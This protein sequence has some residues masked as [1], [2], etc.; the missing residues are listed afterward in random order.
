V[1]DPN[2]IREFVVGTGG[3]SLNPLNAPQD[4]STVSSASSFG[5]LNLTL[6]ETSYDWAFAP[7]TGNF[8]DSGTASC[9]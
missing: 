2:G 6:H 4:N 9:V 8:T 5:V 7:A 1:A 3:R